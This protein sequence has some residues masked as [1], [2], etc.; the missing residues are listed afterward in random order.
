MKHNM[1]KVFTAIALL[2]AGAPKAQSLRSLVEEGNAFYNKGAYSQAAEAYRRA[3]TEDPYNPRAHFNLGDAL[4][5]LEKYDEARKQF[6]KIIAAGEKSDNRLRQNAY[7][8]IGN[9]FFAQQKYREAIDAYKRALDLNPEDGET[10]YNL[11]LAKR[12]L[13]EQQQKNE[14]NKNENIKPS[15]YAKKMRKK[16]GEY[17]QQARFEEAYELMRLALSRD[18]T[19]A[20]YNS[21][22]GRLKDVNDIEKGKLQ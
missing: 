14:Q 6:Y 18:K 11:E 21:F 17:V 9:S 3:L 19:V 10:K 1:I 16:A 5:K 8:N 7:Y 13:T 2:L 15:E 12:K 20:A 22:I 4:F